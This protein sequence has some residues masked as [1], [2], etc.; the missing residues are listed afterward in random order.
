MTQLTTPA[1]FTPHQI[2]PLLEGF[3][4]PAALFDADGQLWAKNAEWRDDI[5]PYQTREI[6]DG[7]TLR[8]ARSHSSTSPVEPLNHAPV[9]RGKAQPASPAEAIGNDIRAVT[10]GLTH[11]LRNPLSAILTAIELLHDV[12][13]LG[14]E[15]TMLLDVVRKESRR[16]SRILTEFSAYVRPAQGQPSAFDFACVLRAEIAEVEREMR[17]AGGFQVQDD[18][19]DE[20]WVYADEAQVDDAL[21]RVLRNAYQ[22]MV[23]AHGSE[24]TL[25]L[26]IHEEDVSS[27]QPTQLVLCIEDSGGGFSHEALGRAFEPFYSTKPHETGLG[28]SIARGEVE[29]AGGEIWVE[30]APTGGARVC[31]RLP[32]ATQTP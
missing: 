10:R 27:H 2:A 6:G 26:S 31:F 13:E 15:N 20:V 16:M 14:D 11:E 1:T 5:A 30:N 8:L 9:E 32:K 22:A 7:W 4:C 12:A 3:P 28:L 21:G 19:P 29:A 23:N 17:H 18:L 25:H 24:R